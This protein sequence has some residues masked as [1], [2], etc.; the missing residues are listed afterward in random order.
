M[1]WSNEKKQKDIEDIKKNLENQY[2]SQILDLESQVERYE[3]EIKRAHMLNESNEAQIQNYKK[4]FEV[5]IDYKQKNDPVKIEKM[6]ILKMPPMKS[7]C[8][9]NIRNGDETLNR[10]F[11]TSYPDSLDYLCLIGQSET[12]SNNDIIHN[13]CIDEYMKNL[14]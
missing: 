9:K 6:S 2:L 3:E 11:K 10:F 12:D 7:L 1:N 13:T 14:K 4:F 5:K 8:I